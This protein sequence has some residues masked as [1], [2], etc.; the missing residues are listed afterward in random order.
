MC[1]CR[2]RTTVKHSRSTRTPRF[3]ASSI[4][5]P[6]GGGSVGGRIGSSG[7]RNCS[8]TISPR[9]ATDSDF[10]GE[11]TS[12]GSHSKAKKTE[13]RACRDAPGPGEVEPGAALGGSEQTTRP[14]SRQWCLR[15][16]R[17]KATLQHQRGTGAARRTRRSGKSR[18]S[19]RLAS[20][21][22]LA[23]R[24]HRQTLSVY[25]ART[26]QLLA[27]RPAG[28]LDSAH[29]PSPHVR[30]RLSAQRPQ[31]HRYRLPYRC[32]PRQTG[33]GLGLLARAWRREVQFDQLVTI[34][35]PADVRSR[36]LS[37]RR[38]MRTSSSRRPSPRFD[39]SLTSSS[40]R[41]RQTPAGWKPARYGARTG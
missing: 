39:R 26:P 18:P 20:A 37:R 6:G 21:R 10:S 27:S 1:V 19:R 36:T 22:W 12:A 16:A 38:P 14:Q 40:V 41:D 11:P 8:S 9:A 25:S 30:R 28:A 32:G 4:V 33:S 7:S 2:R 34:S 3:S 35:P 13:Q 24:L 29:D 17:E 31:L 23:R 5:R 15:T